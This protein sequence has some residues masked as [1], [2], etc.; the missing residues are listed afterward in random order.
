M[1]G[2]NLFAKLS[3]TCNI[4][5]VDATG[6]AVFA[7]CTGAPPTTAN[8]FQ[9]GCVILRTD[10]S[11]AYFNSGSVASPSWTS[12]GGGGG[13]PIPLNQGSIF[14]GNLSNEAQA[15]SVT[16][17]ITISS[18]GV[19]A[20]A[21]SVIVDADISPSAAISLN[22]L[23]GS[24]SGNILVADV[25]NFISGV[26]MGGDATMSPTGVL[27]IANNAVTTA[28]INSLAVTK[29]KLASG[30]NAS[31]MVATAGTFTTV[32]GGT[33]ENISDVSISASD[34][35][36]V[37]VKTAGATPRSVVAAVAG[38]GSITVTMSGDA[39]TDHVLE[40]FA[41]RATS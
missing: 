24:T 15:R 1:P 12:A 27:T 30:I 32:G 21:P 17:D 20:I 26:T 3:D 10:N 33:T 39:S 9:R 36:V 34:R 2:S 7:Q 37:V 4:A 13:G 23:Q 22:K 16:G 11:T 25:F 40:Y 28:K 18:T 8:I 29:A 14:I 5:L 35:V 41:F 6:L 19:T 38:A 31:H